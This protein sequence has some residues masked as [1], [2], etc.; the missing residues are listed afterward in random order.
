MAAFASTAFDWTAFDVDAG[1]VVATPNPL[2]TGAKT[3]GSGLSLLIDPATLDLI[4]SDDGWF[5]EVTDSRTAVMWQLEAAYNG[6]WGDPTSGSRIRALMHGDDPATGADVRNEVLRALQPL[7]EE[8][9]IADLDVVLDVDELA[10]Q[11]PVIL[12][13][14]RDQAT[15]GLVGL[16][17]SP[18]GG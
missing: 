9:M 1:G 4:D 8:Q 18:I 11:R 7:V 10:P 12:I 17:A 15:N 16:A 6:W 2:L 13:N 14:Y 5:V 3:Q